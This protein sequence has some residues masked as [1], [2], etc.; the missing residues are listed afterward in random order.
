MIVT[1]A[2][3]D[4]GALADW[5]RLLA[6]SATDIVYRL[7]FQP[8]RAFEYVSPAATRITGYTPEEHYADP[9]LGSKLV[10]PEDRAK[11]EAQRMTGTRGQPLELRWVRKD[12][13]LVWVEHRNTPV[14]NERG[15]IVGLQGIA[16]D[17]TERKRAESEQRF[18]AEVGRVLASTLD[19]EGALTKLAEV[20]VGFLADLCI[21]DVFESDRTAR[22][23]KVAHRDPAKA[24]VAE[25]LQ[26]VRLDRRR[27]HLAW[28][29]LESRQVTVL[30]EV[31]A[32]Y[33]ETIAQSPEHLALLREL[34]PVSNLALPLMARGRMM[35]VL[36]LIS[37]DQ[38]RRY[39][40][41]DVP[42]AEELARRA[43]LALENSQLYETA[44]KAITAR[45]EILS[46]VA[47]E[48]RNPLGAAFLAAQSIGEQLPP[49]E[50]S[51]TSRKSV[52]VIN[53]SVERAN[54]L[55]QDLL[56][57]T[58]IEAGRLPVEPIPISSR[59]LVM[60]AAD[61]YAPV[62]AESS[63]GLET[64]IEGRLPEVLAD[65][66]RVFQVFSNLVSN[67]IKFTP[68][69]GLVRLGA[70]PDD[71]AVR[72]W[73]SDNGPGIPAEQMPHLFQRFW[74]GR[75]GDRRGAGLGLAIAKGIVEALGGCI[76]VDANPGA[77][78]TFTFTLPTARR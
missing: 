46:V 18:L 8:T 74:Q 39:G 26:R 44:Q 45:E 33:L 7:R 52:E 48:L 71:G 49:G 69:G 11:F 58:R 47:H 14:F 77:G 13:S 54:R 55:I 57:V 37:L 25:A 4:W 19:T 16:R 62:A 5:L 34:A 23:L 35:G 6:E 50:A 59:E 43:S 32:S 27:P 61:A 41:M 1:A 72:F 68:A 20:T 75:P 63:L 2:M 60:S 70:R 40:P 15:E 10:H 66:P 53:R 31:P 36:L 73:V 56:D 29:V 21:I 22:R 3:E 17:V 42:I 51:A 64:E 12:G 78:V 24:H 9:D 67:A 76:W 65:G 30:P 38:G 28:N